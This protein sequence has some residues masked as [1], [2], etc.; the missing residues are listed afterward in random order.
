MAIKRCKTSFAVVTGGT[1]RVVRVGA[2]VEDTDPVLKGRENLFEDAEAFVSAQTARRVEQA[3]ARPG[4]RR[5]ITRPLA[6]RAPAKAAAKRTEPKKDPKD[7]K[8]GE[9]Q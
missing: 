4:E 3:T 2:L 8:G 6:K 9:G 1:P 5:S 7:Q